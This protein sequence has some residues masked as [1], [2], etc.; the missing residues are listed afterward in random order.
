MKSAEAVVAALFILIGALVMTDSVRLGFR[1]ADDGPQA[2]YFPFYVGLLI[3]TAGLVNFVQA[4]LIPPA[5]NGAFVEVG[6]LKLVL[7]VLVP[8]AVYAALIAWIGI[9]VASTL[10]IAYFMRRLGGY[11]WW[12]TAAVSVGNS[13][14]FFVVFEIWFKIPLP[15]GPV[16][17]FL[18]IH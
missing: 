16:E 7:A 15:K 6:Q 1:W 8:T 9:Y 5:K 14:V 17:A 3:C 13:V 4:L 12:K 2:G 10:F 18:R 11:A